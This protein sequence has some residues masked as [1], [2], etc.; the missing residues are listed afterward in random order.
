VFAF[1]SLAVAQTTGSSVYTY[2][3]QI[4][5]WVP[6]FG[7]QLGSNISVQSI[8][9]TGIVFSSPIIRDDA[10]QDV[11][12]YILW[13]GPYAFSQLLNG[14]TNISTSDFDLKEF[15]Y[16]SFNGTTFTIPLGIADGI[17]PT[18]VYYATVIPV[19]ANGSLWEMSGPDIC[20]RLQWW[21]SAVWSDCTNLLAWWTHNSAGA[22][23]ALANIS[24]TCNGNQITLTWVPV[25]WA[26]RVKIYKVVNNN[27]Q[28]TLI[29]DKAMSDGRHVYTLPNPTPPEVVRFVPT[30][31]NGTPSGTERDYTL[32]LCNQS[33]PTPTPPGTS[34][35]PRPGVPTVPKVGPEQ[36]IAYVL[37]TSLFIYGLL[38]YRR[39]AKAKN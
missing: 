38:R 5:D 24:N 35:P 16:P 18:Q 3:T 7:Y 14:G 28:G 37:L 32:R 30:T 29:A 33:T 4:L 20:F 12:K 17:S 11:K 6:T 36:D 19:A 34:T 1:G 31:A 27:Q 25:Q 21:L 39:Y 15:N 10:N 2:L 8:S 9:S 26:D 22:N 13:Y 23:M